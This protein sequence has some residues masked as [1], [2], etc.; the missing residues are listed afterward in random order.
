VAKPHEVTVVPLPTGVLCADSKALLTHG[1][2]ASL[3]KQWG[4]DAL[5]EAYFW[6][7]PWPKP[8]RHK[9]LG[10]ARCAQGVVDRSMWVAAA[11]SR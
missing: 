1:K 5:F 9:A 4:M 3:G 11:R 8:G 2:P 7:W 6:A 10:D